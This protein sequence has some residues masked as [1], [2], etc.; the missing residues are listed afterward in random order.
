MYVNPELLATH[1][2]MKPQVVLFTDVS[3]F[4]DGI[5][6]AIDS[7]TGCGIHKQW[8]VTLRR[9]RNYRWIKIWVEIK[10]I[11][12][13]EIMTPTFCFAAMILASRSAG[14]T[15][16]LKTCKTIYFYT[17]GFK[18]HFLYTWGFLQI[19]AFPSTNLSSVLSR[20]TLSVP[21]PRAAPAF[22]IE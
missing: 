13:V 9:H 8:H 2:N 7:G 16:P 20:M 14:M 18:S 3:N 19:A 10:N 21:K 6:C 11:Q 1:I 12:W 22:F 17:L 5:K 15:L 4:V